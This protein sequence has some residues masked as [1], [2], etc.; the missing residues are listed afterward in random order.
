MAT[1]T[2]EKIIDKV[3]KLHAHAGSAA[4]I[5]SEEEAQAFANR[6]QELMAHHKIEMSEV[7]WVAQREQDLVK[8]WCDSREK[9]KKG[10]E[11]EIFLAGAV[12]K[13]QSCRILLYGGTAVMAFYGL[14]EDT[15]AAQMAYMYL[16]D[17]A[18]NLGEK[19]YVRYFYECRDRG[20]V[21]R[22]RG[23]KGSWLMGFVSRLSQ[24]YR[25]NEDKIR[26]ACAGT[27]LIRI[28]QSL[29]RVDA[30]LKDVKVK[31]TVAPA[32]KNV[33]GYVHGKEAADKIKMANDPNPEGSRLA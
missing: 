19:A 20:D 6:V 7:E 30:A 14:K 11:W 31:V 32:I 5:G 27:A 24:R 15:E 16:V 22:A 4:R 12:A 10:Q 1:E 28:S 26:Q 21:K 23:Y 9:R 2:R 33:K 3:R 25:E 17:A 29:A 18:R 13:A 8:T